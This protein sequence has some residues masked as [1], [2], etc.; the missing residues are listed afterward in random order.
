MLCTVS[1][2]NAIEVYTPV[3]KGTYIQL[4]V[5]EGICVVWRYIPE[6]QYT[7]VHFTFPSMNSHKCVGGTPL[8][9]VY[10]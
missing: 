2:C 1:S 10:V 9:I 8:A 3:A 4:H 5:A 7:P 6:Q